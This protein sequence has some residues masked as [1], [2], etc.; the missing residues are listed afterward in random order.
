M[1]DTLLCIEDSGD[2]DETGIADEVK[3]FIFGGY[4]TTSTG[5]AFTLMLIAAE[6]DVQEKILQEV[7]D[8]L[9]GRS[10]DD[11]K[12]Q[13]YNNMKYLERVIKEGLRLYP[14]AAFLSRT[15][16]EDVQTG[17]RNVCSE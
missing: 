13:D 9:D 15:I 10:F 8:V 6:E 1:L 3:T 7:T 12:I 17:K 2:I 5:L 16:L 4:D 11:L 14:P